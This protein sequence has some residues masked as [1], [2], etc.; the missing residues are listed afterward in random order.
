VISSQLDLENNRKVDNLS[1]ILEILITQSQ[2]RITEKE[3]RRREVIGINVIKEDS[4]NDKF[5]GFFM[6]CFLYVILA[7]K[8]KQLGLPFQM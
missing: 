3:M 8:T 2:V 6:S 5:I 7:K 1:R 4:E